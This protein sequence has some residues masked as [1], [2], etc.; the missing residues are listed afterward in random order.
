M[1]ASELTW[2]T[3]V[4]GIQAAPE[5]MRQ[6][7]DDYSLSLRAVAAE[8]PGVAF[9]TIHRWLHGRTISVPHLVAILLWME[10]NCD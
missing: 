4:G 5:N 10:K 2:G 8:I 6:H 3:I 9:N 7:M 1:A